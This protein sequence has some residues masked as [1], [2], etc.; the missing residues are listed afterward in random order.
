M[1]AAGCGAEAEDAQDVEADDEDE[2][3][4]PAEAAPVFFFRRGAKNECI[5]RGFFGLGTFDH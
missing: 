2:P 4:A 1:T 5:V 3:G